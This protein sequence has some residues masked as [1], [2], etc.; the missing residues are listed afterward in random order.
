MDRLGCLSNMVFITILA[1]A[2]ALQL[3]AAQLC[4]SPPPLSCPSGYRYSGNTCH[5]CPSGTYFLPSTPYVCHKCPKGTTSAPASVGRLSCNR[6]DRGRFSR[7]SG[8]RCRPCP[9]NTYADGFGNFEC[10]PCPAGWVSRRGQDTCLICPVGQFLDRNNACER[11]PPGTGS[12]TVNSKK[13]KPCAKG[14]ARS[15]QDGPCQL[16]DPGYFAETEGQQRCRFC[17]IKMYQSSRAADQCF[18]CP[19][20]AKAGG[21]NATHCFFEGDMAERNCPPGQGTTADGT[22]C[23]ECPAGTISGS[24]RATPCEE[25][26]GN[27]IPNEARTQCVCPPNSKSVPWSRTVCEVCPEGSKFIG[28]EC[29]CQG[30][31]IKRRF[32]FQVERCVCPAGRTARGTKCV[33]CTADDIESGACQVCP[34]GLGRDEE[35]G[36]CFGCQDGTASTQYVFGKCPVCP[37]GRDEECGCP[38]GQIGE[39]A[40]APCKPCPPGTFKSGFDV[41]QTCFGNLYQPLAGQPNC[42]PCPDGTEPSFGHRRC[43]PMCGPRQFRDERGRCICRNLGGFLDSDGSCKNC[44]SNGDQADDGVSCKCSPFR[45]QFGIFPNCSTT[46]CPLGTFFI[47]NADGSETCVP[48]YAGDFGEI[49]GRCTRCSGSVGPDPFISGATSCKL[50]RCP[51]LLS[52]FPNKDGK[53][54]S[55][56]SGTRLDYEQ[57]KCIKCPVG[58]VSRGGAAVCCSQCRKGTEPDVEGRRCVKEGTAQMQCTAGS[59]IDKDGNCTQCE[60]GSFTNMPDAKQCTKCPRGRFNARKGLTRC[61]FCN[62]GRISSNIG[63]TKCNPCPDGS[64]PNRLGT[65]CVPF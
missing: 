46:K 7:F 43:L 23:E 38:D 56:P 34:P 13:C 35:T 9:I 18:A 59:F 62:K 10:K 50:R 28:G 17:P 54:T 65:E 53:C 48:C 64:G 20:R 12:G 6:C 60:A 22:K 1:L 32:I 63:S 41:C 44:P 36:Q 30:D 4:S 29:E 3:S 14:S 15:F 26:P 21:R 37:F 31:L 57:R 33:D 49:P 11:C 42:R 47:N 27:L 24:A 58:A 39:F 16:C 51:R 61:F 2:C 45:R 19:T 40:G 55:C 8:D 25:C 5:A 52:E